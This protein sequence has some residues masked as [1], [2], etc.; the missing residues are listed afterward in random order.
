MTLQNIKERV[1]SLSLF[2]EASAA[3]K[4]IKVTRSSSRHELTKRQEEEQGHYRKMGGQQ[5]Y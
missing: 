4:K 3:G 5:Q 2:H 1:S